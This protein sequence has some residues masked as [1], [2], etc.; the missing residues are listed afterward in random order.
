MEYF[1]QKIKKNQKLIILDYRNN[2]QKKDQL[3]IV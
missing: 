1:K 2:K 3:M